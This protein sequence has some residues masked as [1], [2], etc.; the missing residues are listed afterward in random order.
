[1]VGLSIYPSTCLKRG[2]CRCGGA[3]IKQ[4]IIANGGVI[5]LNIAAIYGIYFKLY[6]FGQKN[7]AFHTFLAT[8]YCNLYPNDFLLFYQPTH[9]AGLKNS[10]LLPP[11][12]FAIPNRKIA[13]SLPASGLILP[14]GW[15]L[16]TVCPSTTNNSLKFE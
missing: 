5:W 2:R 14:I 13:W 7:Q 4:K 6:V 9:P 1:M 16:L 11:T 10:G 3:A 12:N 15:F 8:T